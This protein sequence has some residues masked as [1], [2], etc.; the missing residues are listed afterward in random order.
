MSGLSEFE[1]LRTTANVAMESAH[2]RRSEDRIG[3]ADGHDAAP[4]PFVAPELPGRTT[5]GGT[6]AVDQF[7]H[8]IGKAAHAA[9]VANVRKRGVV[10]G[11]LRGRQMS[12]RTSEQ[13]ADGHIRM[14]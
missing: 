13:Q 7:R 14:A 5:D 2:N 11:S 6:F 8:Q 12:T 1:R 9:F 3:H 4:F 10:S